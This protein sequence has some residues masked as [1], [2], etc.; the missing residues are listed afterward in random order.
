[1]KFVEIE[2]ARA[3]QR[4]I[5]AFDNGEQLLTQRE[6]RPQDA[7]DLARFYRIT[8]ELAGGRN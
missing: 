3:V 8:G 4:L 7:D 5:L 6:M 2:F 1:M